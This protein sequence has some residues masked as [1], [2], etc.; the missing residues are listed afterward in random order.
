MLIVSQSDCTGYGK[1][2]TSAGPAVLGAVRLKVMEVRSSDQH[3]NHGRDFLF[4]RL[5]YNSRLKVQPQ[6]A[7]ILM[8]IYFPVFGIRLLHRKQARI[9][10]LMS[11][12]P[13]DRPM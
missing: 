12:N 5:S 4:D 11:H 1:F 8:G 3:Q 2:V 13:C 6:L 10:Q 7:F 9:E